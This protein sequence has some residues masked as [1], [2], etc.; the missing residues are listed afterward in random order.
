MSRAD[1]IAGQERRSLLVERPS[2]P[3][4]ALRLSLLV[5]GTVVLF[6]AALSLAVL[7]SR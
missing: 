5:A 7:L 3:R 4:R 6:T 1:S 2:L